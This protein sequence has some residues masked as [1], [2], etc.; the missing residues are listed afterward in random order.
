MMLTTDAIP[1]LQN[2]RQVQLET[3]DLSLQTPRIKQYSLNA[4]LEAKLHLMQVS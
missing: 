1:N 2:L 3:T 4:S